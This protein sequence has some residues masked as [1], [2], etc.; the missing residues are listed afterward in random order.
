[1]VLWH[2][3]SIEEGQT[4]PEIALSKE[5]YEKYQLTRPDLWNEVFWTVSEYL[6]NTSGDIDDNIVGLRQQDFIHLLER[7]SFPVLNLEEYLDDDFDDEIFLYIFTPSTPDVD[8]DLD[9]LFILIDGNQ[10][11]RSQ[12]REALEGFEKNGGTWASSRALLCLN[13]I[14]SRN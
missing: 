12:L 7:T 14:D 5:V 13:E 11:L 2:K 8:T 10:T 1:M 3:L 6:T 9:E 4:R